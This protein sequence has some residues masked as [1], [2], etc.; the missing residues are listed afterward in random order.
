MRKAQADRQLGKCPCHQLGEPRTG[1]FRASL[2]PK[3]LRLRRS[4]IGTT[5]SS[6]GAAAATKFCT[7]QCITT[8]LPPGYILRGRDFTNRRL[9]C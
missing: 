1:D 7:L 8:L 4:L 5:F 9:P 6:T 2:L 3:T